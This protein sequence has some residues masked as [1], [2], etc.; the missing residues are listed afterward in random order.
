MILPAALCGVA[1]LRP[2]HGRIPLDGVVGL[3]PTLDTVG[4]IAATAAE[5]ATAFPL[6]ADPPRPAQRKVGVAP[7]DRSSIAADAAALPGMR[8][9]VLGGWFTQTLDPGVARALD[10]VVAVLADAG[11]DVSPLTL[12][13]AAAARAAGRTIYLREAAAS[14][15]ALVDSG[16]AGTL[17]PGVAER[18]EAGAAIGDD[19]LAAARATQAA[20]RAEL[21][22]AFTRHDLLL[23]ATSPQPAPPLDAE[24]EATGRALLHNTYPICLGGV[25]ALTLPAGPGADG[26]PAGALLIAPWDRDERLLALGAALEDHL[27][28]PG[29]D[30]GIR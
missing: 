28:H 4:P 5:L 22:D 6:L 25:P 20:W 2:T 8:V 11:A 12:P 30:D 13:G 1:G 16:G 24:L 10:R 26:L 23:C 14:F 17:P 27:N 9:G 18:L 21:R 3:A 19:E 15:A 29:D 7:G